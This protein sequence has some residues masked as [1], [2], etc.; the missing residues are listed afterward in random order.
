MQGKHT[1]KQIRKIDIKERLEKT[2]KTSRF[3]E[4][5]IDKNR[6]FTFVEPIIGYEQFTKYVIVEHK[7]NSAFKWL[8]SVEE[9]SLAFPVTFPAFFNIEYEFEIPDDKSEKLG[10]TSA[11]SLIALN[12]VTIPNN[13]PQK[14]TINLLAPVIINANN[15]K[16]MQMILQ[17]SDYQ[18]QYPLFNEKQEEV[19]V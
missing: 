15:K 18:V 12:I 14:S 11:E 8:Q 16:G 10:L 7:A 9:P 4:I 2:V 17:N 3:G 5:D 6:I 13:M 19:K 1:K